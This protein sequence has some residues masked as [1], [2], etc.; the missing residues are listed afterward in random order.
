MK[1]KLFYRV[2]NT[3]TQQGLWYHFN[4]TFTGLIHNEFKFCQNNELKMDFD[5]EI[6][7]W[8]SAV[9]ELEDLWKWFTKE[10]IIELQRYGWFIHIYETS[11]YK[12]YDRFQHLIIKQD[13]SVL[14]SIIKIN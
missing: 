12:F 7:G 8:L 11:D 6:V 4:G 9:E 1:K 3:S 2:C 10:D 13:T 14:K 5:P